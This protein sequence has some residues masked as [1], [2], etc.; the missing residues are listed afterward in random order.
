MEW[1]WLIAGADGIRGWRPTPE[2]FAEL[3]LRE[4]HL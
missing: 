4:R 1:L 3:V 2:G